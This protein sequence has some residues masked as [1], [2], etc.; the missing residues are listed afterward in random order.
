MKKIYSV[1]LSAL[2]ICSLLL[3]G[4]GAKIE[5][6]A[7][8]LPANSKEISLVIKADEIS[9]LD[10]FTRLEAA[11]FS[12][13]DCYEEIMLWQEKHPEVAVSY[14]VPLSEDIILTNSEVSFVV[15]PDSISTDELDEAA[16]LLAFLPALEEIDFPE[17]NVD[18][19]KILHII[20]AFAKVRPDIDFGYEPV[21]S[22]EAISLHAEKLDFPALSSSEAEKLSLILP[23]MPE[24]KEINLGSQEENPDLSFSAIAAM[25][26]ARDDISYN[27]KFSISNREFNL[28]DEELNLNHI[29]FDDEGAQVREI[30]SCM[31]ELKVLDMDSCGVSDEAMA[32]IRDDFPDVKVIWRIWFGDCYSVRTDVEKIL[33]SK[34]GTG[35]PLT[36]D[37]VQSLKYCTDV[38]YMD[39]GHNPEMRDISFLEYMPK[40]EV[41]LIPMAYWTDCSVLENCPNIEYLEIQ[42]T[43]CD[44]ISAL[45]NM[46]N[47]KH[48]NIC[49]LTELDDISP[50]YGCTKLERLWIGCLDPVP[51]EQI[52]KM[53]E[54]CPDCEINTTTLDPTEGGWRYLEREK[55]GTDK[56][57]PRYKELREMFQYGAGD[58]AFN[59][60]WNDPLAGYSFG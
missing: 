32:S 43:L 30:I 5:F 58:Y 39:L 7:G 51:Q 57:H 3:A 20:S 2:L 6:S 27:Y 23:A 4:C 24:L 25:A 13:S 45:S 37:K 46:K 41:L 22:G 34:P 14:S 29:R 36:P 44:D 49:Y 1:L 28:M 9:L 26:E 38:K 33:A 52:D 17:G 10:G 21:I 12:G 50:L 19:E 11:D 40:L 60:V 8:A 31:P 48:L 59:F 54:I 56:L 47:L 53:Q 55:Y 15:N 18:D 35:G 42:T 16:E